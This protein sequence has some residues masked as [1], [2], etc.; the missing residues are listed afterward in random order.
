MRSTSILLA[1]SLAT[2]VAIGCP[3]A[4][5]PGRTPVVAQAP[6][7]QAPKAQTPKAQTLLKST[8]LL[9]WP[10]APTE[11]DGVIWTKEGQQRHYSATFMDRPP[12]GIVVYTLS[13]IEWP[14]KTL[15][16]LEAKQKLD[17]YVFSQKRD[18]TSRQAIEYG[19][20]KYP[21]LD[22]T[23]GS[24]DAVGRRIVIVAGPRLYDLSVAASNQ[25]ALRSPAVAEFFHSFAIQE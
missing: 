21:G 16:G 18:E 23:T 14:E 15:A 12:G 22:M 8:F 20:K 1:L 4:D 9:N 11:G 17:A 2:A 5:H 24:G 7:T 3:R 13:V 19:P 25:E 10:G 6:K